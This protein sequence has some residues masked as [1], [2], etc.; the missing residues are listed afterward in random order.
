M[1]GKNGSLYAVLGVASDCS[2]A[3]LRTAYRKLAMKWHPDKCGAAGSSAGGGAEAAK[4]RF[5]KIQGAYAVLSDPN[6]RIL[7][8][9]GAYDSDGDDDR[10]F[11]ELFLRPPAPAPPTSSSFRSAV[12]RGRW[13][14][15]KEKGRKNVECSRRPSFVLIIKLI[16]Q[17]END[18]DN[19][20]TH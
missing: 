13:E 7:Y 1:A 10:Q 5:Q 3:D 8:D 2:D 11:E 17:E 4:V 15:F 12:P 19:D 9:V 20:M 16:D 18:S 14:V 6:K